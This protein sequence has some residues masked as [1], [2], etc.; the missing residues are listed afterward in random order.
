LERKDHPREK[1]G[2]ENKGKGCDTDLI[3]LLQRMAP[4]ERT[5]EESPEGVAK[6]EG[7]PT[8]VVDKAEGLVSQPPKPKPH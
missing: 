7:E 6:K 5:G 4:S 1:R 8:G 2:E 3:H